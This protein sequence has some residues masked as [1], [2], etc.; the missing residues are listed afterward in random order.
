MEVDGLT[1]NLEVVK[2]SDWL[3]FTGPHDSC[4]NAIRSEGR[5]SWR[6]AKTTER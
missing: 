3:C 1:L 4:A 5:F 6:Q 2:E